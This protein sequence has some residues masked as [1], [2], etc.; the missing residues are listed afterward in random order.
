M[1]CE[2]H[3]NRDT[4]ANCEVCGKGVCEEC[5]IEI[6]GNSYCKD[7][8]N[9]LVT[10][11]ILKNTINTKTDENNEPEPNNETDNSH[12]FRSSS[13]VNDI[14]NENIEKYETEE[15]VDT[16]NSNTNYEV[17]PVNSIAGGIS[18]G[19]YIEEL[20]DDNP[21]YEEDE[22]A[23]YHPEK[24]GNLSEES[25]NTLGDGPDTELEAKYEKYLEDLYYDENSETKSTPNKSNI[26]NPKKD[27]ETINPTQKTQPEPAQQTMQTTEEKQPRIRP[28]LQTIK[29]PI[30]NYNEEEYSSPTPKRRKVPHTPEDINQ[31]KKEEE[32][33]VPAHMQQRENDGLSY[34]EIRDKIRLEEVNNGN[35]FKSRLMEQEQIYENELRERNDAYNNYELE[36]REL[37]NNYNGYDTD[38]YEE[39]SLKHQIHNSGKNDKKQKNN[40]KDDGFTKGEIVLSIILIILIIIVM[41]YVIYLFTLS[42]D[43]P[44]YLDAVRVLFSNPGQLFGNMFN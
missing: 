6:A 11:S 13:N 23:S 24:P 7:C 18:T 29:E 30:P 34:E 32:I 5:L 42:N 33:I 25:Y 22:L 35:T 14:L 8:V 1:K 17:K 31:L 4:V 36:N 2:K 3:P 37:I 16:S 20:E 9:E 41:S 28:E 19:E 43:Y 12:T 21:K 27:E 15:T 38:Y 40:K 10:E 44:S 26:L 39:P